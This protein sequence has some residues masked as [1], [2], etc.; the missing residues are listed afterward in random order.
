MQDENGE[1]IMALKR[2][3]SQF[4]GTKPAIKDAVEDGFSTWISRCAPSGQSS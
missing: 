3:S 1:R 4:G 2:G